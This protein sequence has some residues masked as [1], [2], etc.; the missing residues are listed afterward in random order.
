MHSNCAYYDGIIYMH[1]AFGGRGSGIWGEVSKFTIIV[2][3]LVAQS[4]VAFCY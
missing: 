2:D 4:C 3:K 1:N